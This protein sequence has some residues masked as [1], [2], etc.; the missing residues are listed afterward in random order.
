MSSPSPSISVV[1]CVYTEDRWDQICAA[2]ESV[3]A[4]SVPSAE[5]I[6]AVDYNEALYARLTDTQ[7]GAIVIRNS[8]VK[9]LSGGRNTA[10]SVAKGEIIAY[11]DDDAIADSDWLKY[12][13]EDFE[14]PE[15]TG[16]GGLT[17]PDWQTK[18]PRWMPEEFYWVV[19][20]NYLGLPPSGAPV[21][22][23]FGGNMAL[24]RE[25]FDLVPGGFNT[26]IG[27]SGDKQP[28]GCEET[29]FC[30]RLRE[31]KPDTKLIM[32]HRAKIWH[33]ASDNRCTFT[34]FVRRCYA[35]GVSKA[36]VSESVGSYSGLSAERRYVT[37]V[38]P[39][40]VARGIADALRGDLSGLGRAGAIAAGL[41]V[42]VGGYVTGIIHRGSRGRVA[43]TGRLLARE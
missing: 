32:E 19:G 28:M 40:G 25:V 9:G 8:D 13:T 1:I 10:A 37:R 11:L 7:P 23:L 41:C 6:L 30:I 24:R 20:A 15:I 38:L 35:E 22:N 16:V 29:E 26:G 18:R 42:T 3:R 21:R 5:L 2:I 4:Q 34:Y 39:L 43:T 17:L 36:R 14:D 31:R 27:R 12:L 33:Y